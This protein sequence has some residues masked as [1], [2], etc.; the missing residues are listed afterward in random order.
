MTG[1][2]DLVSW[3]RAQ[4]DDDERVAR[5][6]HDPEYPWVIEQPEPGSPSWYHPQLLGKNLISSSD[7]ATLTPDEGEHIARWDPTRVLAEIDAKRRILEL[8]APQPSHYVGARFIWDEPGALQCS[9]CADLCHS[10]S[11]LACD[12]PDAPYPCPTVSLLALS[13][14]DRAGY[15]EEWRP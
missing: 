3:L 1:M 4:L 14:A 6:A 8:H 12:T 5:A 2:D 13:L 9:H 15:R 7:P 10:R 11:G